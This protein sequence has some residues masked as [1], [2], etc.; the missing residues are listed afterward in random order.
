VVLVLTTAIGWLPVIGLIRLL[1]GKGF[2]DPHGAS[3]ADWRLADLVRLT[4]ESPLP[5][6]IANSLLL[7]IEVGLGVL[8]LSLLVR[9]DAGQ[10]LTPTLGSRILGRL[11]LMPPMVQ[12]VGI[13]AM[14]QLGGLIMGMA[15]GLPGSGSPFEPIPALAPELDV[16]RNPWPVLSL[17]VG[18]SVGLRLLGSWRRAAEY[19]SEESRSALDAAI[20]AGAPGYRARSAVAPRPRR[21]LGA[22]VS[23]T[24]LAAT[25]VV[26]ALLFTPWM[27]GRTVGPALIL[28]ADGDSPCRVQAAAL[29]V[30]AIVG[31]VA[32]L[33]ASRVAPAPPPEWDDH[34]P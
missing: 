32:G 13:L 7:G 12:A 4:M 26:P 27:D 23:T 20:L 19:E 5:Q 31:N 1:T 16:R 2:Y 21:W 34:P 28:L 17:A 10:R 3:S 11:A 9:P 15:G 6:V 18:L 33:C 8:I 25:N 24:A 29:A 30:F 14:L 22:V